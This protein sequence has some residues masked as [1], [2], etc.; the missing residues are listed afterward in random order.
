[1]IKNI[2]NKKVVIFVNDFVEENTFAKIIDISI[3]N[4]KLL[5]QLDKIITYKANIYNY[6]VATQ[7]HVGRGLERLERGVTFGCRLTWISNDRYNSNKPFD[8]SWWR[9]GSAATGSIQLTEH[10]EE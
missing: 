3:D 2:I 8:V 10:Y 6:V 7:R 4:E 1:M 9:G 5:L